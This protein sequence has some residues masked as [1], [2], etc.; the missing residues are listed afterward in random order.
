MSKHDILTD[1]N[2][3]GPA[4]VQR[5]RQ[6]LPPGTASL[7]KGKLPPCPT[8]GPSQP[9]EEQSRKITLKHETEQ[10]N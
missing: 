7:N 9:P 10:L 8:E 1:R 2:R 5:I 3:A 6:T 4:N